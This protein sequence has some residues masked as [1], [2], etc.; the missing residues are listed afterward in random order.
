MSH[1]QMLTCRNG[2]S[3]D[4]HGRDMGPCLDCEGTGCDVHPAPCGQLE[5]ECCA[6]HRQENSHLRQR[7]ALAEAV[8]KSVQEMRD[9]L[10]EYGPDAFGD[11][12]HRWFTLAPCEFGEKVDKA[13]AAWRAFVEGEGK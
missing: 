6:W 5:C 1:S 12:H 3:V 10:L 4:R 8:A 2:R 11:M 7:L 13:L 9:N